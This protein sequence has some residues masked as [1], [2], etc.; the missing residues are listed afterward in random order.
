MTD[1]DMNRLELDGA[2][3][4]LDCDGHLLDRRNWSEPVAEALARRD[5]VRLEELH[6]WMIR[7]V[8]QHFD[9]YGTPPLMRAT[10][11]TM[12]RETACEDATSRTLYL[13]FPDGP[14]RLACRYAGLPKPESCIE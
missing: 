6:W 11:R 7:F 1:M 9:A 3:I 5:H 4:Q 13:L 12:R 10:V 8:Q 2:T 14:I